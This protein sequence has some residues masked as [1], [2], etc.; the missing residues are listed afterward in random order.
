MN[1]TLG[2]LIGAASGKRTYVIGALIIAIGVVEG[3]LGWDIPN[4]EVGND[5]LRWVL[6]GLG[7]MTL[8]AGIAKK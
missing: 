7:L 5:W 6:E 2:S 1:L 8:R 3:Y 4:V